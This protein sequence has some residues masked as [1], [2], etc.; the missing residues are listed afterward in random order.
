MMMLLVVV[1]A[2]ALAPSDVVVMMNGLPGKMG[3]EVADAC[4]RRGMS[5]AEVALT[6]KEESAPIEVAS[7]TVKLVEAGTPEAEEAMASVVA[8]CD[9]LGKTLVAIDYTVPEAAVPNAELYARHGVSFVMGTTGGDRAALERSVLDGHHCAVIAPNMAKQIVALQAAIDY[10]ATEFP[11]AFK[12]Y[13]LDV[14]ESHQSTKL[15]TSGTAKAIVS[16]LV[17]LV[18]EAP[19]AA[20]AT[21][22]IAAISRVRDAPTQLEGAGG[23][24]QRV[25]E[26]ALSGHAYHTYGLTSADDSVRFELRHNVNGRRVYAEGTADAALF[27]A[28]RLA[29]RQEE[30]PAAGKKKRLF[31]MIDVLKSGELA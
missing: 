16:A 21:D 15:D 7:T 30:T 20:A 8:S 5:L 11:G 13:K 29:Q 10:A 17:S 31:D 14:I 9:E 22:A 4:A 24:L 23:R 6:G 27:L 25:P 18:D 26:T 19:D 2:S 12:G 3:I 1:V 28:R